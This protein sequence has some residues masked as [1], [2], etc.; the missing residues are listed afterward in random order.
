[1]DY[2]DDQGFESFQECLEEFLEESLDGLSCSQLAA[3]M[4]RFIKAELKIDLNALLPEDESLADLEPS[5]SVDGEQF[6]NL[7]DTGFSVSELHV[8]RLQLEDNNNSELNSFNEPDFNALFDNASSPTSDSSQPPP[9]IEVTITDPQFRHR[10]KHDARFKRDVIFSEAYYNHHPNMSRSHPKQPAKN[11]S[12]EQ[13]RQKNSIAVK[14][15]YVKIKL[16]SLVTTYDA[17]A[18]HAENVNAKRKL[19]LLMVYANVL[20][21]HLG[22][23]TVDWM[24]AWRAKEGPRATLNV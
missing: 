21:T 3:T 23:D 5:G 1:M 24:G 6:T 15:S 20:L 7:D 9:Y 10:Y 12:E 17:E 8:D 18:A 2:S 22:R 14:R 4:E 13:Y 16:D 19:A 11:L